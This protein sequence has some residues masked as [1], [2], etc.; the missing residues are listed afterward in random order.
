MP[1]RLF[2][3]AGLYAVE[4]WLQSRGFIKVHIPKK[5]LLNFLPIF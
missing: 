1:F 2:E 3:G 5:V 4:Y